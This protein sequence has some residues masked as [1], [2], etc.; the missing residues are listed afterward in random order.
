MDRWEYLVTKEYKLRHHIC[1][2]YFDNMDYIIDIGAYKH[3]IDGSNVIA[4]DPLK[5]I[6]NS[7]HDS[8]GQWLYEHGDLLTDNCGV[9]ALGLE[10]EGEESE[11]DAFTTLIDR[12]R[13]AIIEHS[14]EHEPSIQQFGKI[15]STT[16]KELIT[17]MEFEFCSTESPGFRPHTRRRLVVLERK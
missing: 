9:M 4:I 7:Y 12:S 1:K 6:S 17:L 14:V 11:W 15:M 10:I 2:Y 3:T 16:K 8:V 5:S 13:I